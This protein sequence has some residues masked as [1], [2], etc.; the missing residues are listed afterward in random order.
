MSLIYERCMFYVHFISVHKIH[1]TIHI[2]KY[3]DKYIIQ[4]KKYIIYS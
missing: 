1:F 2:D 3:I 4:V